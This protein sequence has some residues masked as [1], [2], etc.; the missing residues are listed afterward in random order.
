MPKLIRNLTPIISSLALA[1]KKMAFL[2][3]PRQCGK[4]T[5]AKSFLDSNDLYFNWDDLK[6]RK[7]WT[8]SPSTVVENALTTHSPKIVLDEI[9]K[10][11]K[12]KNQ[13]KGVFDLY[14]DQLEII[15]TGSAKLN[16]YRKGA[17]SLVGRFVH[18]HVLP[19]S[20]C[21]AVQ[22][23]TF[24][25]SEMCNF[26][27]SPELTAKKIDSEAID[28]F[29]QFGGF[30]EPFLK[31][32]NEFHQVWQK[33]RVELLI[34]Q[35]MR[36]LSNILRLSQVEVL[37]SFLPDRVGSPLSVQTLVEDLDVSFNTVKSWLGQLQ[38]VYYH[39]EIKPFSKSV[40]RSLKKEGKFYLYDISQI[41][42]EGPRF[43]NF[44]ALQLLKMVHHFNDTGQARVELHYL[45]NKEK[46]EVDFVVT[47]KSGPLF[48]V[49]AKLDD[50]SIDKNFRVFRKDIS[51]PH[52]QVV[53]RK[54][55]LRRSVEDNAT[56]V[57]SASDFFRQMP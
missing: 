39:F 41:E 45:R 35:D 7:N 53:K 44:V 8:K 29:F 47:N 14:S 24:S 2:S 43:E 3:G 50:V 52:F 57:I 10:N 54:S 51:C 46:N 6:F 32:N 5:L 26:I 42:A 37:A 25:Y 1:N 36:D 30:P 33:N 15:V 48:T 9:H 11:L 22:G 56:Y 23:K 34:R 49:E 4:T 38:N 27:Q 19:L 21:E 13:L 31:Q 40:T 20:L 16:T 28:N 12:W 55:I 18:F 17:D